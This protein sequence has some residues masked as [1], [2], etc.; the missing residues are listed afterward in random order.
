MDYKEI[1]NDNIQASLIK[2]QALQK[3]YEVTLQQYQEA[4]KNY[5]NSLQNTSSNPCQNYKSDSTGISQACYEK[6]WADQGCTNTG[7]VNASTDWAKAQTLNGL[8]NDSYLW[9]TLTDDTH[10]QGCYGTSTTYTTNTS[11]TD[12]NS[13][14]YA[15]LQSRTWW[16]TG[17]VAEGTVDTQEECE[18]MCANESNC[19][20]ATFNPVKRYCWARTGDSGITAGLDTDYALVPQ[21]KAALIVMKGLNDKLLSI[22]EQITTELKNSGPAV[23]QQYEQKNIQQQKLSESYQRLLEQKIEMEKQLQE[24]Y[25]INE[26]NENQTLFVNQQTSSMKFWVL[27]TCLVLIIT[28]KRLYGSDSPPIAIILWLLIIVV[29][30]VLTYSLSSPAGFAMWFIV[31]LAIVLMKSGHLPSP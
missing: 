29:L 19:T 9:A 15:A 5:I 25:S 31:L 26:E 6:I 30:I 28:L 22:N 4:G 8:V 12:P 2:V 20:G 7:V 16:G 23:Q 17:G 14:D 24:Y 27:I 1:Q 21:Q 13:T 18:N 3:E 10:R 11:A